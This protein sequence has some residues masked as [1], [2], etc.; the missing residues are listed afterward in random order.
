ME[1]FPQNIIPITFK[2][3]DEEMTEKKKDNSKK[4]K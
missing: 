4:E 2:K 3:I 1:I